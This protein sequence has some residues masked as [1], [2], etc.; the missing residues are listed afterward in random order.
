[1]DDIMYSNP[2]YVHRHPNQPPAV[3]KSGAANQKGIAFYGQEL[4]QLV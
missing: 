1:M 4:N 2:C 3:W